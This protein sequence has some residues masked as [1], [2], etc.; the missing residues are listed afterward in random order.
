[1]KATVSA[2][3]LT[4]LATVLFFAGPGLVCVAETGGDSADND[5]L[6]RR[7]FDAIDEP[8]IRFG[9]QSDE[10]RSSSRAALDRI[11]NF[12]RNC[13]GYTIVIIGHSDALGDPAFNIEISRRRAQAVASYLQRGGVDP[14][15]LHVEGRGS[16]E[17]VADNETRSGRAKNRR[18]EFELAALRADE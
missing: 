17:P 12:A 14:S 13:P 10:L 2:R 4:A 18:I 3:R 7:V 16:S 9:L 8:D 1:M 6:C 15:R 5:A 11:I